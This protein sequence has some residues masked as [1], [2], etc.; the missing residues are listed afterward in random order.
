MELR[1]ISL[2]PLIKIKEL[3]LK[4]FVIQRL[5]SLLL[6]F[7]LRMLSNMPILLVGA[8]IGIMLKL[9]LVPLHIWIPQVFLIKQKVPILLIRTV[10]KIPPFCILAAAWPSTYLIR[11]ISIARALVGALGGLGQKNI[12]SLL[13][14]S[15]ITHLGWIMA[16][17][18]VSIAL[19]GLYFTIYIINIIFLLLCKWEEI[20]LTLSVNLLSLGGMPPLAGFF[21]KLVVLC[22]LGVRFISWALVI[23]SI[24]SLVYYL[25]FM[26][27]FVWDKN[28]NYSVLDFKIRHTSLV[29]GCKDYEALKSTSLGIQ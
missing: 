9:G 8:V 11:F 25:I 29:K 23:R 10:S 2:L 27:N 21:P 22:S 26:R 24:I 13:A 16:A 7:S 4:Y 12:F 6:L 15:S 14:Y 3:A 19:L 18:C 1:L 28:I 5:S 17:I 20:S